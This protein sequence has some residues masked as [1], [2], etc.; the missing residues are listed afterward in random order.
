MP[1][2]PTATMHSSYHSNGTVL[3]SLKAHPPTHPLTPCH[4]YPG[5]RGT[6]RFLQT[7]FLQPPTSL[8]VHPHY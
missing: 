5:L 6:T 4:Y 8:E 1:L 3:E 2:Q 7:P